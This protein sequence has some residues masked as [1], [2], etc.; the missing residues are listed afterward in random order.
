MARQTIWTCDGCDR[1]ETTAKDNIADNWSHVRVELS[2]FRR[3]D[4]HSG[5][6][7]LCQSCQRQMREYGDPRR[8][9][10]AVKEGV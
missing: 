5:G 6:Y 2:G 10:R 1:T 3:I 9:V 4:N 7:D 8:W